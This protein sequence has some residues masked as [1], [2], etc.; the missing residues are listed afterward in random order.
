[1]FLDST[2]FGKTQKLNNYFISP[3]LLEEGSFPETKRLRLGN[4]PPSLGFMFRQA[5]VSSLQIQ[6]SQRQEKKVKESFP[7]I[8][9]EPLRPPL[10]QY[11]QSL[12]TP[13]L[14]KK[15]SRGKCMNVAHVYTY[16]HTFLSAKNLQIPL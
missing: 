16:T 15:E 13:D 5:M 14:N 2:L 8:Y 6:S 7:F 12:H 9:N 3:H 10:S 11:P 1:M 4:H